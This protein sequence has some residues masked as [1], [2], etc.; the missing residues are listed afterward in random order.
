MRTGL[1]VDA[2]PARPGPVCPEI[3]AED[4]VH[5]SSESPLAALPSELLDAIALA[6]PPNEVACTL[7]LLCRAFAAH[8]RGH[9]AVSLSQPVPHH[10]FVRRFG[11]CPAITALSPGQLQQLLCLTAASGC[12][13]NLRAV[14]AATDVE[15]G[16]A[17][18][19]AAAAA[20]A[21]G[22]AD[23]T[24]PQQ[25]DEAKAAAPPLP[26][27]LLTQEV[28]AAA[29]A[30]GHLEMC[31]QLHALGCPWGEGVLE[32]A[33]RGG[34][35]RLVRA[36]V[37]GGC[38]WRHPEL[39]AGA[40]SSAEVVAELCRLYDDDVPDHQLGAAAAAAF[41]WRCDC[42]DLRAA[43]AGGGVTDGDE[44]DKGRLGARADVVQRE[45]GCSGT[46]TAA[47][48]AAAAAAQPTEQ[49]ESGRRR[50]EQQRRP[51]AGRSVRVVRVGLDALYDSLQWRSRCLWEAA[52]H[53]LPLPALQQLLAHTATI[54]RPGLL[55]DV[56]WLAMTAAALCSGCSPDDDDDDGDGDPSAGHWRSK[57]AWLWSQHLKQ[58][59]Q[60]GRLQGQLGREEPAE[61]WR[62]ALEGALSVPRLLGLRF[63]GHVQLRPTAT[64]WTAAGLRRRLMLLGEGEVKE[65]G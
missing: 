58:Q 60:N 9:I 4:P 22:E 31:W 17:S 44:G 18:T 38:P 12:V 16:N 37:R 19:S 26:S 59:Q 23:V 48:A 36:L 50:Q 5:R 47:A 13:E 45:R 3:G 57:A 54:G 30:A 55:A 10:A 29:A 1:G 51:A 64:Q 7:R 33:A 41:D 8:F 14:V 42:C 2:G 62:E 43:A 65:D 20:A 24:Q 52:A 35:V 32:A 27:G 6:L 11:T 53:N 25:A 46:E 61:R 49:Q 63:G 15:A 21:D 39:A 28:F 34:H 56:P 40:C